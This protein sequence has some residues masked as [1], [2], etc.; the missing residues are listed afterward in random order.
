MS[1]LQKLIDE[2]CEGKSLLDKVYGKFPVHI[3]PSCGEEEVREVL[4]RLDQLSADKEKVEDWD[5]D[6]QDDIWRV[7]NGFS[8]LLEAILPNHVGEVCKGLTSNRKDTAF[9]V[10]HAL[11]KSPTKH[12]IKSVEEYLKR[13]IPKLHRKVGIDALKACKGKRSLVEK[14]LGKNA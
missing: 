13:D 10:V 11:W 12:A 2:A 9:Y 14:L 7:Q 5:G 1:K 8:E 6:G 3:A 4:L